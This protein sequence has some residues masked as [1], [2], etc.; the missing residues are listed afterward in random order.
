MGKSCRFDRCE[1]PVRARG[2]CTGHYKQAMAGQE[3]KPLRF[4][5]SPSDTPRD[6]LFARTSAG[7]GGCIL[8]EGTLSIGGYGVLFAPSYGRIYAHRLAYELDVGGIPDGMLI[9]HVCGTRN[10]VN[11][12]HLEVVTPGENADYRTVM[13]P[14]NTSGMRCVFR[15]RGGRGWRAQVQRDGV[16]IHLGTFETREEAAMA[17]EEFKADFHG[18]GGVWS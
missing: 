2:L 5:P 6:R 17:V 3:L 11:Y 18:S 16:Q 7:D 14:N 1:K 15:G 9:N 10:C 8:F 13:M 12:K 4:T